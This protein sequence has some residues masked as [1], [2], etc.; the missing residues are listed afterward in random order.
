[1]PIASA[2][3]PRWTA[4][5]ANNWYQQ[6]GWLVGAN[7]ITATST[8]QIEMWQAG[9]YDPRRI[10]GELQVA[11]EIGLNTV[12]VFLHDQLWAQDRANF[13]RRVAQFVAIASSHGIRPL[14][15]LFDSCWDPHPRLGPQRAPI[16]GVHN[17]RWVQN[18]GAE[19][20][21]RPEYQPVLRDYVTGMIGAFATTPG[22]SAG[23]CGM[24]R[25]TPRRNTA[26]SSAVTRKR[27]SVICCRRCSHGRGR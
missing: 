18:L 16:T 20:I 1:M 22:C 24:N 15:V 3:A 26:M 12:R 2:A 17:S 11:R 23:T 8:N 10:N 7:Y 9:T 21:D 6:Q 19:L 13:L 5:Q 14:F 25:A 4:E 27:S